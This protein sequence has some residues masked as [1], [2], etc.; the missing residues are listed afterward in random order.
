MPVIEECTESVQWLDEV[1]VLPIMI[2]RHL[3]FLGNFLKWCSFV[4]TSKRESFKFKKIIKLVRLANLSTEY[5][6]RNYVSIPS[7]PVIFPYL[8]TLTFFIDTNLA[9]T[10]T[11]IYHT[12]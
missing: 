5:Y 4:E 8:L 10:N 11:D 3:F 12:S 7:I 1:F 6:E 9:T 2:F